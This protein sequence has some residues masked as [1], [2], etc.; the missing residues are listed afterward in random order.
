V[1]KALRAVLPQD[2]PVVSVGGISEKRLAGWVQANARSFGIGPRTSAIQDQG[3][4]WWRF[5]DL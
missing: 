5:G 4:R 3:S 1:L 2:L